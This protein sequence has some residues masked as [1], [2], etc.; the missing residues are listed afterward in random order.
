MRKY[1]ETARAKLAECIQ[2]APGKVIF[3]SSA[4]EAANQAL[5]P[6]IRMSGRET[7]VSRL[8]V[9]AVE[10]PCILSGRTVFARRNRDDSRT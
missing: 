1:I 6:V 2:C 8:Y 4:T 5:S 7:R 10:H 9:S 3:T